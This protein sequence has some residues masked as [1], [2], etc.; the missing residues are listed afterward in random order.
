MCHNYEIFLTEA[1]VAKTET[2]KTEQK[3]LKFASFSLYNSNIILIIQNIT[4]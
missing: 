1:D 4:I 3:V 2:K